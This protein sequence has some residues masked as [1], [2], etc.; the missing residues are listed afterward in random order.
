MQ[1]LAIKE[2]YQDIK[3][4]FSI[5]SSSDFLNFLLCAFWY[6]GSGVWAG[7]RLPGFESQTLPHGI[8][9]V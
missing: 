2:L 1:R 5:F 9:A 3:C 4:Y 6:I 8:I 7:M